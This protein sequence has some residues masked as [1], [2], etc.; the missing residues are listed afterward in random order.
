MAKKL[1]GGRF[2]KK[3]DPLVE[4][5]TKSIQYDYKLAEYDLIGSIIHVKILKKTGYLTSD[6]ANK[7]SDGLDYICDTVKK[8]KFKFDRK[9]EDIHTAIQNALQKKVGDLALKLHTARSRNDQVVFATKMYCNMAIGYLK[10]DI[11]RLAKTIIEVANDNA[12]IIIPGFT[13]MQHAQPVY[14]NDYLSAYKEML[15]RDVDRLGYVSDNIKICMGAGALAG[16]PISAEEYKLKAEEFIKEIKMGEA[17]NVQAVTNSLDA[18]SD[19]DFVIEI[20]SAL[21]ILA[22]HLSRLAEDFIIW[23]TKEFDFI[24][25]DEAFCTGSSLMP[26]KKNADVLELVRGYAGRLYGNLVSVLTMMKGLPLTYN[27]DMQLDKEPLFNSLEIVSS[28]LK[29]LTGLIKTLKFNKEKI[30]E[31]LKDESLYATDLVYYLV[32]E[33]IAFK[34]AHTI[35]GKLIKYSLD[36]EILIKDMPEN[37]LKKFS[38]KIVKKE[39][40]KLF[41]PLVSVKSK[42]S[43]KR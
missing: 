28:E 19:R 22:M 24:E 39:F 42:K 27:R 1:W 37:L 33:G 6:E 38:D 8:K 15:V 16:T 25:I 43:I 26:Q 14:L 12:Q 32:D 41:D 34:N 35:I 30:A 21:S 9:C 7:L 18:V 4:E 5:F 2:S 23:S 20:I 36:N 29:V 3:T 40:V 11:L 10:I 31:H 13:H 17:C